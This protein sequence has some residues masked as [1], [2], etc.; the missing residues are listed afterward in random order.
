MRQ[1]ANSSD[2]E[3]TG[4]GDSLFRELVERSVQG[5]LV[6]HDLKPLYANDACARLLGFRSGTEVCSEASLEPV[7]VNADLFA[8]ESR[9]L[10]Q[11]GSPHLG[12]HFL[13]RVKRHDGTDLWLDVLMQ[14]IR[15]VD[16]IALHCSLV[17]VTERRQMDERARR[18]QFELVDTA[19]ASAMRE[20]S[21][22]LL[23]QLNQPRTA[24]VNYANAA[25]RLMA[26]GAPTEEVLH[27]ID[28]ILQETKRAGEMLTDLKALSVAEKWELHEVA[29]MLGEVA[30]AVSKDAEA[31][32]VS[33][34][35]EVE[36]NLPR[37]R[38]SGRQIHHVLLNLVVHAM[39]AFKS[40]RDRTVLVAAHRSK[41]GVTIDITDSASNPGRRAAL[42][43]RRS[44]ARIALCEAILDAHGGHMEIQPA[45]RGLCVSLLLP[46]GCGGRVHA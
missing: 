45:D 32:N 39:A 46:A 20:V 7:F 44:R 30:N 34:R 4:S 1:G 14:P 10:A 2:A 31:K 23:H 3:E 33:L 18:L 24:I 8:R 40:E 16:G 43:S 38:V 41:A 9:L 21:D 25:K 6:H 15:W 13:A 19:R 36:A 37:L 28:R 11:T 42:Y 35:L 27:A 17:D 29:P 12:R 26:R 22:A 5:I